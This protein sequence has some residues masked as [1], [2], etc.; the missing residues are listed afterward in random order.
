MSTSMSLAKLWF[1]QGSV[2][3]ALLHQHQLGLRAGW[4]LC[5]VTHSYPRF[6]VG[7]DLARLHVALAFSQHDSCLSRESTEREKLYCPCSPAWEAT[8]YPPPPHR[9][10]HPQTHRLTQFQWDE[11]TLKECMGNKYDCDHFFWKYNPSWKWREYCFVLFFT[12]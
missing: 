12:F 6:A 2:E 3:T 4:T 9:N 7:W 8:Q 10:P 5:R 1:R 11:E